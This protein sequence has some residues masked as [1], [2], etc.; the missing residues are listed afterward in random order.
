[1]VIKSSV[2]TYKVQFVEDFAEALSAAA[3][4]PG[5][6]TVIDNTVYNL[7]KNVVDDNIK[8][9]LLKVIAIEENKTY[10]QTGK[11]ITELLGM[12]LRKNNSLLVIGGGI[13]QDIGGFMAS[14]L[15]R[16]I[17]YTLVPTTLLAQ[18]DSCIGSKTSLNIANFKNQLGTFYPPTEV[19]VSSSVL[20][21]LQPHEL[22]SG[23]CEAMK[24]AMVEG[25]EATRQMREALKDGL[26]AEALRTTVGQALAIKKAFIEEDEF[27]KGLR[28]L[29]NYG[30]TFGH[31][32]ES[33]SGY[34]I[35]H[36]VAVGIGI[37]AANFYSWKLA[38]ISEAEYLETL[39]LMR[40]W[41]QEYLPV[42]GSLN[43]DELFAAMKS[44][45]KSTSGQV[46]FILTRGLGKMERVQLGTEESG[47]L[48]KDWLGTVR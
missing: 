34:R 23:I 43:T 12:G 46:G 15:F 24:L 44:D 16:G 47:Q 30:H 21:T 6:F 5:H 32:F 36:G 1:M 9:P 18:C 38:M 41:C 40:P 19:I 33:V 42:V 22:K 39:K 8:G 45:K 2:R 3:S 7:Y 31:A 37:V 14:V 29:L 26:K 27:D 13:V 25:P 17:E 35:P 4:Q 20:K 48:L 11:F 10:G 28:N